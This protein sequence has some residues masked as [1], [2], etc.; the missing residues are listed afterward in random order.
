L[1]D[2]HDDPSHPFHERFIEYFR[3]IDGL[4]GRFMERMGL[5]TRVIVLS[6]HGFTELKEQVYLN[7]ILK[8]M[9]YLSFKRPDP[10]SPDDIHPSSKAFAMD[11]TRIYLNTRD[12]FRDGVLSSGEALELRGRLQTQFA[13]MR[14]SD[15]GIS[16]S[17]GADEPDDRLFA[18][19]KAKEELYSGEC[20][21]EAPDLVIVP[22]RGYDP[23][24]AVNATAPVARDIFTGMHTHDDAFLLVHDRSDIGSAETPCISDVA[25]LI[26]EG[27]G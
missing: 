13:Q 4:F 20:F 16:R 7:H 10:Q 24:A 8:A 6:D 19:V 17:L 22:K 14:L 27:L 11:P 3:R 5:G 1:Y 2:A 26:I 12:R 23:K 25:D 18:A 21:A 15:V 9:G